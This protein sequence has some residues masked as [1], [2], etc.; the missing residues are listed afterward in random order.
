MSL[1]GNYKV[2]METSGRKYEAVYTLNTDDDGNLT[3]TLGAMGTKVELIRGS[4]NGNEFEGD[5]TAKAPMGKIKM[6]LTGT[7]DGDKIKGEI[8]PSIGSKST[9]EGAKEP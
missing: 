6:K 2:N 7:I 3:G 5:A 8:K 1:N 9:F 4:V